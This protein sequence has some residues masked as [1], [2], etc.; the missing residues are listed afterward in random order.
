M[1]EFIKEKK[2]MAYC[3]LTHNWLGYHEDTSQ[4]CYDRQ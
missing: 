4:L 2:I 1:L 3:V